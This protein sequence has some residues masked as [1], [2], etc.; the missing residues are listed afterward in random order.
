[1]IIQTN[2]PHY[3]E[4]DWSKDYGETREKIYLAIRG[5]IEKYSCLDLSV[6]NVSYCWHETPYAKIKEI[7]KRTFFK[8]ATPKNIARFYSISPKYN[9]LLNYPKKLMDSFKEYEPYFEDNVKKYKSE[10]KSSIK[11]ELEKLKNTTESKSL[12]NRKKEKER[13]VR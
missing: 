9:S 13:F 1:M 11:L 2:R 6:R 4:L 5:K 3:Y 8:N 10:N 12:L 7:K